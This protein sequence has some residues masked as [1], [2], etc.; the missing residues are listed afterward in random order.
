MG[1]M[2]EST[3]AE[4]RGSGT[5]IF[6]AA[7]VA[8]F[9]VWIL[10]LP[11]FPTQDGPMHRY[12]VHVLINLLDHTHLY[13]VYQIRHPFPPYATHY[14]SLLVLSRVFSYDVAEKIFVCVMVICFAYGFRF[15]AKAIGPS[16]DLLSL[17]IA[18][19][20]LHWSLMMGFFNYSFAIGLFLFAMGFWAYASRGSRLAWIGY[21]VMVV[22]LTL[23]HPVP[24][25][26]LICL[27][28]M[29]V[30]LQFARRRNVWCIVALVFT[31]LA[32]LYPT[33]S[34]DKTQSASTLQGFGLHLPFVST[35]A[36]LTGVSP[37]NTRSLSLLINAQ[38]L[39]LYA[40]IS[41]ALILSALALR[42]AW[43]TR[44]YAL[45][46]SFFLA[47]IVLGMSLP[48]MPDYVN[49]SGYFA[50]RLVVF[51]WLGALLA[52]S[53]YLSPGPAMRRWLPISA[54]LL[55]AVS[56]GAAQVYVRPVAI[57]LGAIERQDLPYTAQGLIL[58]TPGLDNYARFST[59]LAP[60]PFTW[61]GALPA[62]RHDDVVLD[63][64]WIDQK[65]TP[66]APRSEAPLLVEDI[67]LTHLSAT[68]PPSAPGRSLPRSKEGEVLA[69]SEFVLYAGSPAELRGGLEPQM[70]E[71]EAARFSCT[72]HTWYLA[73]LSRASR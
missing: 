23:T 60:D 9:C 43:R 21:A 10:S 53:S 48:F 30:L 69:A 5:W 47:T 26:I 65:I 70:D 28:G 36:L 15:C 68:D 45:G 71:K 58:I 52:A 11:L 25:L 24:L 8:A 54:V 4:R 55:A 16:G 46:Q 38:R 29:D 2:M 33:R 13:D 22:L 51:L 14:F 20:F 61:A 18:P 57:S 44:E 59:Q 49:G 6:F 62:V 64:P 35:A 41:G 17:C 34:V 73:C 67:R 7:I 50:T 37:Y 12:Y 27:C 39:G 31:C 56:L 63:S 19:L 40:L 42:T 3:Q 32:F 66:I 72:V 1:S